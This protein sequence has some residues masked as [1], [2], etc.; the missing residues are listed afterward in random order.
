MQTKNHSQITLGEAMH[1]QNLILNNLL[2]RSE[3]QWN[4]SLCLPAAAVN[5]IQEI[6]KTQLNPV[7]TVRELFDFLQENHEKKATNPEWERGWLA[8]TSQGDIYGNAIR[9][10]IERSF[11]DLSADLFEGVEPIEKL[12]KILSEDTD[13]RILISVNNSIIPHIIEPY[14]TDKSVLYSTAEGIVIKDKRL[15]KK[16]LLEGGHI[17][18][19]SEYDPKRKAFLVTDPMATCSGFKT[20]I[21]IPTS[22]W[23]TTKELDRYYTRPDERKAWGIRIRSKTNQKKADR[24]KRYIIPAVDPV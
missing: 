13:Q 12:G 11:Q 3:Y 6:L 21:P 14:D 17:V 18:S 15:G 1:N 7:T 2:E 16:P 24:L 23:I 10:W 19:L 5:A 9:Y 20:S 8:F 4:R 22:V